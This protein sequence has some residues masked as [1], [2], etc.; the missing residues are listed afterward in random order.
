[1][2]L[3]DA[4]KLFGALF[5]ALFLASCSKEDA[6]APPKKATVI[7]R[8][9]LSTVD[10]D[11]VYAFDSTDYFIE[12]T[13]EG[14]TDYNPFA[15][16]TIKGNYTIFNNNLSLLVVPKNVDLPVDS[17]SNVIDENGNHSLNIFA[18]KGIKIAEMGESELRPMPKERNFIL[19]N[20]TDSTLTIQTIDQSYTLNYTKPILREKVF[21]FFEK[22]WRG[23]LG[24]A[25]LV[26][27]CFIFS[28]NRRKV[29]WALVGKGLLLQVVLAILI[30]KFGPVKEAFEFMAKGFTKVIGFT[31]AGVE[32]LLAQFGVGKINSALLNFAFTILPTIIFFSALTSLFFYWGILQKI[33]YAFA[34]IMKKTLRLSG[35]ES[36]AAAG[37]VFLGQTESALLIKPYLGRMTKAEIMSL[38]TGGMATIAGGVLASYISFLGGGDP[39]AEIEFAKHLMTA[40]V[41]SAPAAI[42]AAKIL[43]PE[44]GKP[45]ED[46][47]I[48]TQSMG[49]NAFEA[50]ANGTTDG[51]KLAVNVGAMLLVFIAIMAGANYILG[52]LI[53][54]YTGLN[55]L[56]SD[57]TNG[58]YSGLSF[59]FIVGYICAPFVWL[60]GIPTEDMVYVGELLG[61]KTILNEFVAYTRLGELKAEG[62]ISGRS[63]IMATYILCGFA[64]FASIGIQVGGIGTLAPSK[65]GQL[66]K[67]GFRAL[68]GG[69]VACLFTATIVGMLL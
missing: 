62:L 41:I 68:I 8:W 14:F 19:S 39:A 65:R 37:N 59:E 50:I 22:I 28:T 9:Q 12:F 5:F 38:M 23:L 2:K 40:S 1:M 44:I 55:A 49:V 33:I 29:D 66:A 54:N 60:I 26:I 6:P 18:E 63:V 36:L 4:V 61:Q 43:V 27:L 69:T 52:N 34:W 42:V 11:N 45:N 30:L 17:I 24:M 67:F 15:E 32:F 10:Y 48:N 46:F 57:L 51:V 58:Q 53:G 47:Q 20:L 31:N 3:T 56:V 35:G 25:S 13:P 7:G 16:D 64:N 21:G